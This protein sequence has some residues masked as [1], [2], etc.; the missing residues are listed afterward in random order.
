MFGFSPMMMG[1]ADPLANYTP[2]LAA[3]T[4]K[5]IHLR[6]DTLTGAD[7]SSVTAW[8]N[9]AGADFGT[10][11]G[12]LDTSAQ[13][14]FNIVN[15]ANLTNGVTL[16]T[17]AGGSGAGHTVFVAFE[18][19]SSF[20]SELKLL[21]DAGGYYELAVRSD[22][23]NFRVRHF[24]GSTFSIYNFGPTLSVSTSYVMAIR[25]SD[26]G[27]TRSNV[28]GTIYTGNPPMS[29]FADSSNTMRVGPFTGCFV[30]EV[31]TSSGVL[32]DTVMD[33]MVTGLMEKWG[34]S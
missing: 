2:A 19:P 7:G 34:I 17:M 31:L 28:N 11:T 22:T 24:N 27:A 16:F 14:G 4:N 6:A 30:F 29:S 5:T 12:T 33:D 9:E 20:P 15:G 23:Q 8:D 21:H 26:L 3:V 13:N 18:M 32:S 10:V 1:K 25:A